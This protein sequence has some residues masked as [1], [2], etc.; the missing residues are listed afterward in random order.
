MLWSERQ[1]EASFYDEMRIFSR[2]LYIHDYCSLAKL[3]IARALMISQ[4]TND[5]FQAPHMSVTILF[6][7]FF[8]CENK[9]N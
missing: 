4:P 7:L 3:N 9:K 1:N 6:G 8:V 2:N 5:Q